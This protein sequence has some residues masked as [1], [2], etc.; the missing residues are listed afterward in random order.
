ML[1]PAKTETAKPKPAQPIERS[2]KHSYYGIK[3]EK[4]VISQVK[5]IVKHFSFFKIFPRLS[6]TQKVD[7]NSTQG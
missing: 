2:L 4:F 6:S 3:N 1:L 5:H 7:L